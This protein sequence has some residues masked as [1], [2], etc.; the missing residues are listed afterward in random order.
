MKRRQCLAGR[1]CADEERRYDEVDMEREAGLV[2]PRLPFSLDCGEYI[3]EMKLLSD[4]SSVGFIVRIPNWSVRTARVR[5]SGF[6]VMT[7]HHLGQ[8]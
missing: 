7:A 3:Q 8:S 2:N 6:D 5:E 4:D 1:S